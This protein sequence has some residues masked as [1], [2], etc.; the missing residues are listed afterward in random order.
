ML[1][2]RNAHHTGLFHFIPLKTCLHIHELS[3]LLQL[4]KKVNYSN[5]LNISVNEH[6][7]KAFILVENLASSCPM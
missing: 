6:I 5:Y 7:L 3:Q 4:K 2:I 1:L